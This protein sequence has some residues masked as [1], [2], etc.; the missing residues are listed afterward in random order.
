MLE[1]P[2][3]SEAYSLIETNSKGA[4]VTIHFNEYSPKHCSKGAVGSSDYFVTHE[5]EKG[6]F[7]RFS[8]MASASP[9]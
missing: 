7:A 2:R 9:Q 3:P 1:E 5:D 6:P 8:G 4:N